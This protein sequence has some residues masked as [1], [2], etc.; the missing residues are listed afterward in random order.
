MTLH[1]PEWLVDLAVIVGIGLALTV[2]GIVLL[3][4]HFGWQMLKAFSK[5]INW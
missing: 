2:V 5:G 4:A 3:L 1:I